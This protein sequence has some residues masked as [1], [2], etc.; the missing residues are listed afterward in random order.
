MTPKLKA[1]VE[2]YIKETRMDDP[3]RLVPADLEM[4]EGWRFTEQERVEA[5]EA[6]RLRASEFK[7]ITPEE[8]C[9]EIARVLTTTT[10][11]A[12]AHARQERTAYPAEDPPFHPFPAEGGPDAWPSVL[13]VRK[14]S[15]LGAALEIAMQFANHVHVH[16]SHLFAGVALRRTLGELGITDETLSGPFGSLNRASAE[17]RGWGA[18]DEV[19]AKALAAKV[20][21]TSDVPPYIAEHLVRYPTLWRSYARDMPMV[22]ARKFRKFPATFRLDYL[23]PGWTP[24]M[25]VALH[26]LLDEAM[27]GE[28]ERRRQTDGGRHR[29]ADLRAFLVGRGVDVE[30]VLVYGVSPGI[31]GRTCLKQI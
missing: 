1:Y 8:E 3:A 19:M 20:L 4:G 2:T 7:R 14:G 17:Y 31:R 13:S 25:V 18:A 29:S 16:E 28:D 15:A 26:D 5:C 9:R 21:S 24:E 22:W 30:A 12:A 11:W 10:N 23:K 27:M 6:L